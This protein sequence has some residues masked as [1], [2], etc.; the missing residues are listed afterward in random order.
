MNEALISGLR[1]VDLI[2]PIGRG[3]R[4][5]ILGD[6]GTGKT[7]IALSIMIHNS[8][9]N[10]LSTIDGW[11]SKRL[12]GF[13]VGLNQNLSKIYQLTTLS[14]IDWRMNILWSTNSS[15]T[16]MMTF[17]LPLISM[18]YAEYYRDRGFDIILTFDDLM[19]HAKSYRQLA[20]IMGALPT[21]Q[22]FPS[23]I[24]NIHSSILE[25]FSRMFTLSDRGTI[26]CLPILETIN[27][28]ISEYIATNVISITDGQLFIDK[29]LFH[30]SMRPSIDSSLSVSRIGSSAQSHLLSTLSAGLKNALTITRQSQN[31]SSPSSP[32]SS[33]SRSSSP[34]NH[35]HSFDLMLPLF[36][37]SSLNS[38]FYQHPLFISSI[39]SS[40]S[41]LLFADIV[42]NRL[43]TF[44]Y[45]SSPSSPSPSL[46]ASNH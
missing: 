4:E 26:S 19:K 6:R 11:G 9:I 2:L 5:L 3:Q 46:A 23:N 14:T 43:F 42:Y 17:A 16:A 31:S 29:S 32:P 24:F 39:E 21:R 27:S 13:Y 1:I 37:F 15:S 36:D 12:F 8:R 25:R 44:S 18:T 28:D 7:C 22:S 40:I 34:S 20:L 45:Q 35:F 30:S 10:F 38:I 41:Y 33:I